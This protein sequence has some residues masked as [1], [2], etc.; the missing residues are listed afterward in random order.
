MRL[1]LSTIGFAMLLSASLGLMPSARAFDDRTA[2]AVLKDI[3][4]VT[5]PDIEKVDRKDQDSIQKFLKDRRTAASKKAKLIAELNKLAPEHESLVKLLPE[6]WEALLMTGAESAENAK[7]EISAVLAKSK[8]EKLK[9]EAAF[10]N[11]V[12][13]FRGRSGADKQLAAT[14]DFI[15]IA[16][17]DPRAAMMLFS[18]ARGIKDQAEQTA[19]FKRIVKDY[20]DSEV[21]S[22]V[23]GSLKQLD[24]VGKPF[25]LDFTDA[26]KGTEISFKT[27]LKGKVVVIDFWATW[28]RPCVAEMPNMKKIYAEYHDKG[29]EFVGVSLDSPKEEGGLDA[30]KEFVAKNEIPWPQ[31]YQGN[32]WE[33]EFSKGWGITAIPA[34]FVVDA[35]GKLASVNASGML[36][37]MLPDLLKKAKAEKAPA[38]GGN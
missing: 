20:P 22:S 32:G 16:P 2:E 34:L 5:M 28:C 1:N 21:A 37:E 18:V 38:S 26:I 31:Y 15:K 36:E 11:A 7:E 30:L 27:S 12:L 13:V 25:A 3:E 23:A 9:T 24:S 10:F 8:N 17:K 4:G 35:E 33:S 19:V 29:V 14:E 6:R